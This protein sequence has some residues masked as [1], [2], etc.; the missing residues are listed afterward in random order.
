[1]YPNWITY[2]TKLKRLHLS[3]CGKLERLP[4]LGKLPFLES[5][6][7]EHANSLKKVGV[8]FVGIESNNKKDTG[9]TSSLVLFPKLKSLTFRGLE[10]WE[11]WDGIGGKREEGGGVTIMPCLESLTIQDCPK[12]KALPNF[13]ETTPL[14]DLSIDCRI[15]NWM[16][17][18]TSPGRIHLQQCINVE[19]LSFLGK[20]PFLESLTISNANSLK[21]VGVEFLGI[22]PNNNKK[23]EGST[24]SSL[25]LFPNLKSLCFWNLEEWEEWDGKEEGEDSPRRRGRRKRKRSGQKRGGVTIMPRLQ[26]LSID[27]C[28]KLKWLPDFLPTTQLKRLFIYG[29]PI[30]SQ[31]YERETGEDWGKISQIPNIQIL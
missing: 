19:H 1:M 16:T 31:R 17:L 28:P 25:I 7:I 20:L 4:P 30:L 15:S 11:E 8:E 21:K 22:E 2:L 14:Q 29:C 26:E 23:E 27:D 13:L 5:L 18:T 9:S 12:L 3:L 24:S 10:E 6:M